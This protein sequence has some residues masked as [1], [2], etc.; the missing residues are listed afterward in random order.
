MAEKVLTRVSFGIKNLLVALQ[1][2]QGMATVFLHSSVT[3][4]EE[5][6]GLI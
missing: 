2:S 6:I 4:K 1:I 3:S 5:A